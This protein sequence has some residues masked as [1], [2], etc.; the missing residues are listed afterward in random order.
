VGA[1][2]VDEVGRSYD[3]VGDPRAGRYW[4]L[5]QF[6]ASLSDHL[7]KSNDYTVVDMSGFTEAQKEEVRAFLDRL[8][9]DDRA[10]VIRIGF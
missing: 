3:F 9:G 2:V 10:K 1:E 6:E 8:P 7:L 5:R 4:N